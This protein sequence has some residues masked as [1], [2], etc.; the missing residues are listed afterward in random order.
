MTAE[1]QLTPLPNAWIERLFD[2]LI[3]MYGRKFLDLWSGLDLERVKLAWAE[4]LSG[5][6]ANELRAGIEACKGKPWP[7]TLPEFMTF[8]RPPIDAKVEWAE[9]VE[10]MRIRLGGQGGDKW[11]RN[12]VYW[13]AVAIGSFELN[14]ASWEQ[15]R[16]RWEAA[17]RNAKSDPIPEYRAAIPAPGKTTIS[18]E[19]AAD[20]L[21]TIAEK[22]GTVSTTGSRG[23][24]QWAH[25]LM[26]READGEAL[27]YQ[28]RKYWREALRLDSDADAKEAMA[29]HAL[30]G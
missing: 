8:C 12:E 22:T 16:A 5:Y 7:P 13:A 19:E 2:R 11:S 25:R 18:R 6:T 23:G 30:K 3:A 28:S 27:P 17:I 20:R 9:A 21:R 1:Q 29:S 24:A 14:Q 15:I 10:Q 4:D 26:E